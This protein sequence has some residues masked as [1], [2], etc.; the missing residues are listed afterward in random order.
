VDSRCRRPVVKLDVELASLVGALLVLDLVDP[1]SVELS[2]TLEHALLLQ[3]EAALPLGALVDSDCDLLKLV[4][5]KL[6]LES[7]LAD[8]KLCQLEQ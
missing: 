3:N 6:C 8:I 1:K 7:V 5:A 4:G 2:E